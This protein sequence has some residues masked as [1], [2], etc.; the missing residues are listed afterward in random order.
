MVIPPIQPLH[1]KLFLDDFVGLYGKSKWTHRKFRAVLKRNNKSR[2]DPL[3]K[4][5]S[6]PPA[7]IL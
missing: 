2:L 3:S 5:S 4:P 6:L 7:S 1:S